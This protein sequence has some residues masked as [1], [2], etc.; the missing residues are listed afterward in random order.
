[1]LLYAA[2]TLTL[3]AEP[4]EDT[5]KRF[6]LDLPQDWKFAPQP[7][8]VNGASFQRSMQDVRARLS[9]KVLGVGNSTTVKT[10]IHQVSGGIVDDPEVA[11]L[12]EEHARIAGLSA[13][14]RRYTRAAL[15]GKRVAMVENY[16]AVHLGN[17][18]LIHLEAPADRFAA[19]GADFQKLLAGLRF[20]GID[21]ASAHPHPPVLLGKWLMKGTRG[22]VLE[23]KIDGTF[24]LDDTPGVWRVNGDSMLV[25]PLGG[26]AETFGW[27]LRG[28]HL[29]LSNSNMGGEIE[30]QRK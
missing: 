11:I 28:D 26:G 22:T 19:F 8:E 23:L 2:L 1:M 5:Q 12:R 4:F 17:G 18:Y 30:Y 16:Y 27:R 14:K 7:G 13:I 15:G 29:T 20:S 6:A 21:P 24:S 3:L 9:V 25:R 10:F